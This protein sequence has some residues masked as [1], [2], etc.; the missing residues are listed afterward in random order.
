[1][2]FFRYRRPSRNSLLGITRIKKQAKKAVGITAAMK[3]V[4]WWGN[5]KR[6]IKR[7]LGYYST[8]GKLLRLGL[9]SFMGIRAAKP[10]LI[11]PPPR[12]PRYITSGSP[13]GVLVTLGAIVAGWVFVVG[14]CDLKS[15]TQQVTQPGAEP[16][17]QPVATVAPVSTTAQQATVVFRP[18]PL[19]TPAIRIDEA[20]HDLTE[21]KKPATPRDWTDRT[22]K[23]HASAILVGVADGI[24]QL[25]KSD[26]KIAKVPLTKLSDDDYA[27]LATTGVKAEPRT[28]TGRIVSI[29]DGDTVTVLDENN[30]QHKIRLAGIDAPERNQTS[31]QRSREALAAKIFQKDVRITW[32]ELD[33]YGRTIGDIY[34]DDRWINMEMV[35]EGWAWH[36]LKYSDSKELSAAEATAQRGKLGLWTKSD[37]EPPWEFRHNEKNKPKPE[38]VV[39]APAPSPKPAPRADPPNNESQ[40]EQASGHTVTGTPT[41][42]GPRGGEYHYSKSGKKV[43]ERHKR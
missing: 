42:T 15:P 4:R 37:A 20:D 22:G 24:V 28:L 12:H 31:G 21:P 43:Y 14:G 11:A 40:D 32:R 3:P 19:S 26:Q 36:Y 29:T 25:E 17:A 33:K 9:P 38:P 41:F 13:L 10:T 16:I 8:A 30:K 39:K 5:R 1:M 23:F 27:Y 34:I 6:K 18:T 35:R 7:G 2:K